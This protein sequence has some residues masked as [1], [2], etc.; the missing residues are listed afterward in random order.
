VVLAFVIIAI[1]V[2]SLTF[3]NRRRDFG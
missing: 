2:T 3:R 1:S